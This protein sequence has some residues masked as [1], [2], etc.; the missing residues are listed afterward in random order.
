MMG[1]PHLPRSEAQILERSMPWTTLISP[2]ELADRIT[3]PRWVVFDCRHQ[4]QDKAYG[5]RV[6]AASHIP[7]ARFADVDADLSAPIRPDSG[8]HPLPDMD[9]FAAWLGGQ[10]VGSGTQVVAY[11]D[12][13][14]AFAAR[15]W[16]M[17]RYL[18]HEAVAVLDGGMARWT[19]EGR[20]VTSAVPH[21]TPARFF[22]RP[23]DSLLAS[24]DMVAAQSHRRT[25]V[26]VDARGGERYRGEQEPIDP[27][28]GHIPGAINL[29]FGD[30]LAPDGTFLPPERL[31]KRFERPLGANPEDSIHYC[32]SGVTACHNLLAMAVAGLPPGRLFVGS[33]SLW[34][35]D[36][37]RPVALGPER[38]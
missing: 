5:H 33:W 16:W 27:T 30:N 34:C 11:D 4:L 25:G 26:L 35:K 32:G 7:G 38:G 13:T 21:P 14:G 23:D 12:Q 28:P 37:S 29:P 18:G 15:L 24:L 6:Y 2:A 36:R 17:I 3:D 10:G 19:R 8:R 31:R 9:S 20:L 22:A 1:R